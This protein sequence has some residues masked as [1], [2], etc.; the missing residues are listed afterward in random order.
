MKFESAK[1]KMKIRGYGATEHCMYILTPGTRHKKIKNHATQLL[2]IAD[3]EPN[4]SAHL[5]TL[6]HAPHLQVN[7]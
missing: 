3:L 6:L 5:I 7:K 2:E 4:Y 1:S